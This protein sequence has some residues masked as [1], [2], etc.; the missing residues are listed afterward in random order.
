MALA[1]VSQS[2]GWGSQVGRACSVE[3]TA[4]GGTSRSPVPPAAVRD[5]AAGT[6]LRMAARTEA[7]RSSKSAS[8]LALVPRTPAITFSAKIR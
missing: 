8:S 7:K 2:S 1:P 5:Q 3:G 6:S 4:A